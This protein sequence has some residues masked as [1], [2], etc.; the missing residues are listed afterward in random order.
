M[1][2]EISGKNLKKSSFLFGTYHFAD[3]GFVDTM[4]RVNEKLRLADAIVGEVLIDKE[5]LT[6]LL[7]FMAMKGTTL[8]ELLTPTEY[9]QVDSCLKQFEGYQ[10]KML[11]TMKPMVVQA[12]I[13]QLTAP[14]TFG[15]NNPPIDQYFQDYGRK[16]Q[17]KVL[18]LE[19]AQEQALLL[20]GGDLTRQK[21]LLLLYVREAEKNKAESLSMYK[22]YVSQDLQNLEKLLNGNDY[23]SND[24]LDQLL[25]NR[26]LKWMEKLPDM[27]AGQSLFVAVGAGHLVGK[28]GLISLLRKSG[29]T[30][31]PLAT[32]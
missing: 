3:K 19:T 4:K 8:N 9:E 22:H 14:S 32:N 30:V 11:N 1:L 12:I 15:T 23:Y 24:E 10:L 26:N 5:M 17:R 2:W 28:D 7:P 27:M 13:L 31:K 18:A 20:F 29:Y 6:A 25:K 16:N 21:E